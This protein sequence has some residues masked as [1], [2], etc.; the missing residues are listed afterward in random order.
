MVFKKKNFEKDMNRKLRKK[1]NKSY[2]AFHRKYKK[3]KIEINVLDD[4]TLLIIKKNLYPELKI[5]KLTEETLYEIEKY[6]VYLE[7]SLV[8][9]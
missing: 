2:E 5:S 1:E 8:N 7:T 4:R 3:K 9:D 6:A